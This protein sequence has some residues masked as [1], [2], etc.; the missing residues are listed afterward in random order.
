MKQLIPEKQREF[1]IE[2]VRQLRDHGHQAYWAGGCVRDHLLGRTPYDFD[3]ATSA[4]PEQIRA[5]FHHRKTLAIGAAFGVMTVV[6]P[7]GAGQVEV[8]TFRQD[9]SY[10]DGRHPDRI[11]FS[12]PE[13]DA[14]RRDFTINGMFYDPLSDQITD[15][16]GGEADLR[17]G[18][19]RAIGDPR[20][21]FTEDKLRMLR[22]VRFVSIFNFRF[23]EQTSAAIREMAPQVTVVSAERI[24]DEMRIVLVHPARARAV[25][26]MQSL[27]LLPAIL[28]ELNSFLE[29]ESDAAATDFDAASVTPNSTRWRQMLAM[30]HWLQQPSFALALAVLLHAADGSDLAEAV[31]RRWRLS[32]RETDRLAWLLA[33]R[34]DL[35][36]AQTKQWSVLQPLLASDGAAELIELHSVQAK[37]GQLD[38][39]DVA[40]CREQLKRSAEDLNPSPLV[41]GA[42]LIAHGIPRGPVFAKLLEQARAAQLDGLVRDR[43]RA[44]E[45]VLDQFRKQS[46]ER[47]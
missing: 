34:I 32:R 44:M 10:S 8:T 14:K 22:A 18:L 39:A 45:F 35:S 1:A 16:V 40:F 2:V 27:G 13:E 36:D 47:P 23:E 6:G 43:A 30:L 4:H 7:R 25:A 11:T 3:V 26:S 9:V 5:V 19:V 42:D 33:R 24:A 20:A 41:G 31:G 28:P 12:S 17:E 21:R 46:S 15:F 29:S 38:Q 37:L